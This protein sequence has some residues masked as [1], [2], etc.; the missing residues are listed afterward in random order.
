MYSPA[1]IPDLVSS[2]NRIIWVGSTDNVSLVVRLQAPDG[3]DSWVHLQSKDV[4]SYDTTRYT[5]L[6]RLEADS[7]GSVTGI[8]WQSHN[9]TALLRVAAI[10]GLTTGSLPG[11][12]P[13]EYVQ[14]RGAISIPIGAKSAPAA[15]HILTY[16]IN[17]F[18]KL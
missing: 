9:W 12:G 1:D 7:P 8:I 14:A 11:H 5:A 17:R 13:I 4:L 18:N 3:G 10:Q 16:I 2:G 15:L 6:K